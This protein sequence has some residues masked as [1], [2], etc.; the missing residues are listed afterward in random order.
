MAHAQAIRPLGFRTGRPAGA[1]PPFSSAGLICR[2]SA[3]TPERAFE[4]AVEVTQGNFA[5]LVRKVQGARRFVRAAAKRREQGALGEA[6]FAAECAP[7]YMFISLC[8]SLRAMFRKA[9]AGDDASLL[10]RVQ[11]A[12]SFLSRVDAGSMTS[13][14]RY[15][16]P[17]KDGTL[18]RSML[19]SRISD[20]LSLHRNVSQILGDAPTRLGVVFPSAPK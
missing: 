2:K 13:L 4:Q 20:A 16:D 5:R 1:P 12:A 17:E 10:G 19:T 11:T 14:T 3:K 7:A 18:F 8:R 6:S 9:R 15:P